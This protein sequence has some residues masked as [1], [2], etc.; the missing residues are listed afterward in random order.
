[1]EEFVDDDVVKWPKNVRHGESNGMEIEESP[2][3]FGLLGTEEQ[4][5]PLS[6]PEPRMLKRRVP[7][8]VP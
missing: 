2:P 7:L 3:S 4:E 8:G 6:F 5:R 1:M